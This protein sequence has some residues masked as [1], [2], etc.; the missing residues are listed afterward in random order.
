MAIAFLGVACAAVC[1]PLNP[2][3]RRSEFTFY[4][5][6]LRAK[7]LIVQKGLDSP[8]RA[9]ATEIGIPI[10]ELTPES[11]SE[12]RPAGDLPQ[13]NHIALILHTSGTTSRPKIVPLSH[14]NL[15]ASARNIGRTL[16]LT[17]QDRCLNVMP[18]FHIHGL[19]AALL[20]SLAAGGSVVCTPGFLAPDFFPWLDAFSP[21]WYTAVPTIHQGVLARAFQYRDIIQRRPLRFIRSSSASLPPGVMSELE[22]TF[23]APLIEAYGMTEAA[24]QMASNPLPPA[25]RK[26]GSVGLAAGPEIAIL[27]EPGIFHFAG[28]TPSGEIIIRGDNVT[29]GYEDNPKANAEAYRDGWFRTGDVGRLDADGYLTLSGRAKEMINRGGEKI[30]PREVDEALLRHPAVAQALAF[31]V[32]DPLLGEDVAAAVVLHSSASVTEAS[33]RDFVAQTLADFKVP[34]RIVVL[35][36]IPKGPTGK[37]QR[38]GLAEKLGIKAETRRFGR[39]PY[40]APT[41]PTAKAIAAVWASVLRISDI[42]EADHFFACGGDSLLAATMLTRLAE[43]LGKRLPV[44][45][46][47]NHPVLARFAA[48]C[49]SA[50]GLPALPHIAPATRSADLPVSFAQERMWFLTQYEPDSTPYTSTTALR[51]SGPL[52][53]A[54]LEQSFAAVARRHEILRTVYETRGTQLVQQV[55]DSPPLNWR[56]IDLPGAGLDQ[57]REFT[58]RER[59]RSFDLS[60]ELPLRA[61]LVRTSERENFLLFICQHIAIDG[62]SKS[63]LVSDLAAY[64]GSYA[65]GSEL[66]LP[67]LAVQYGDYAVW[68]HSFL[69]GDMFN[70][71]LAYWKQALRDCPAMLQLPADHPRPPRQTFKGDSTHLLIPADVLREFTETCRGR[72]ATLFMGLLA[73]WQ[74]LL[75]RY[76][77]MTDIV[78]GSPI[79]NREPVETEPLIG[80]FINTLAL[81]TD[82]SD[83]PAFPGLLDRVRQTAL[84]AYENRHVPFAA[85]IEAVQ[86]KRSVSHAPIYQVLLQ[87]RNFPARVAR[88]GG[89]DFDEVPLDRAAVMFDMELEAADHQGGLRLDLIFNSD[90]FEPDTAR[91]LLRHFASL[92]RAVCRTPDQPISRLPLLDDSERSEILSGWNATETLMSPLC[93]PQLFEQQ[94]AAAAERTAVR[95]QGCELTYGEL[96]RRANRIAH[97]LQRRGIRHG[98]CIGISLPRSEGLLAALL[99]VLKAGAAYLPLDTRYP[100]DRLAFMVRDSGAR[101]VISESDDI[102]TEDESNPPPAT[103]DGGPAYVLYTSGSTGTPKGVVIPHRALINT[104]Q[105]ISRVVGVTAED[106][107]LALTTISFDIAAAELFVPLLCG[108]S[109]EIAPEGVALDGHRL[110][111]LIRS[112]GC[113]L[114]Q[115]TPS[116]WRILMAAG[117]PG[118]P[119]VRG[120]SGGEELSL[121]LARRLRP[122]LARLWNMYG[123]T[124]TTVYSTAAEVPP[125]P[126]HVTIGRPLANTRIYIL[127]QHRQPQPPGVAGDLHIAGAGLATGYLHRSDLTSERFVPDPFDPAGGRMY[128]TGDVARFSSDGCIEFLGRADLQVKIRGF[129]IEL[130]E[131]E[132]ALARHPGIQAAAVAVHS[133]GDAAQRLVAYFVSG[134]TRPPGTAGLRGFLQSWLPEYMIPAQFTRVAQLPMTSNGKLDRKALAVLPVEIAPGEP[135]RPPANSTEARLATICGELLGCGSV[136][137]S[138]DLFSLGA[139]SLLMA[140]LVARIEREF[141]RRIPLPDLFAYPT[142]ERLA[143]IVTGQAQLDPNP[144][145]VAVRSAGIRPPLFW[146]KADPMFRALAERLPVDQ[147]VFGLFVPDD[148]ALPVPYS[149]EDVAAFHLETLRRQQPVGPYLLGGFC[150]AGLVA[151]EMSRRLAAAGEE[152]ALLALLDTHNPNPLV[153]ISAIRWLGYQFTQL[154]KRGPLPYMR[155]KAG[156]VRELLRR[157]LRHERLRQGGKIYRA[158]LAEQENPQFVALEFAAHRYRPGPYHGKVLL[159]HRPPVRPRPG[160]SLLGW[161]G[162]MPNLETVEMASAHLD[163]FF[164]PQVSMLAETVAARIRG[165]L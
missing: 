136:G 129:R 11:P 91:R 142:V 5:E 70:G 9:V 62:W 137:V 92:M 95:C 128:R 26:P 4:F 46:I 114:L 140:M 45:A 39:A 23:G 108:G 74:A 131:I 29:A 18:L 153:R 93:L 32:P 133:A 17:A 98:D 141:G 88:A 97:G 110:A 14:A 118:S 122:L 37:P 80:V 162:L 69:P 89:L 119:A 79:A 159:V 25:I 103:G 31:A 36:E 19:I 49:D 58:L 143:A 146:I 59:A 117:W 50:A 12:D 113:T 161:D 149:I 13:P 148:H 7:L 44:M 34:R 3:Y 126:S 96:N 20:S 139:H 150:A 48:F 72:Q 112:S 155:E 130:E 73:V 61:V 60:R 145:I 35:E 33:L 127:D 154:V 99:G 134:S 164:E 75:C 56:V 147:P 106:R 55:L 16:A 86:P 2:A 102:Q 53:Q 125:D 115:G 151:Y 160:W 47:F 65:S 101:L 111:D 63:V 41:T 158:T 82:L 85:V 165:V 94:A 83:D 87:L 132:S 105:S 40:V 30:A 116:F 43:V 77:G 71:E 21:T 22:S 121:S 78:V 57:L 90:L 42:G 64:Y 107:W 157:R 76:S 1:A 124:E 52:D 24:H 100:A 10:L 68:E 6:D 54:A 120:I 8:A 67:Q 138:T 156:A 123:P 38:I 163:F 66:S 104:L 144:R 135:S 84:A 15:W 51:L 28:P 27:A 81:R 152:V 109:V